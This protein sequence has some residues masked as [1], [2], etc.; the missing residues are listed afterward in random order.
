MVLLCLE[1][2][3]RAE[4]SFCAFRILLLLVGLNV[5]SNLLRL[6]RNGGKGVGGMGTLVLSPRYTVT[7]RMLV[8]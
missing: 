8:S 7:T 4:I 3:E 2:Q 5:H 1:L 6:I